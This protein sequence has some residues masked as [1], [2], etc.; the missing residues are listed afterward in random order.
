MNLL[1]KLEENM[2][3][4]GGKWRG[5][6]ENKLFPVKNPANIEEV[7]GSYEVGN[8]QTAR[9]ALEA[10]QAVQKTWQNTPP[11]QRAHYLNRINQLL[12][13][14][15]EQLARILTME[16]GKPIRESIGEVTAAAAHFEWFA[17]EGNRTYGRIIPQTNSAK[18][19]LVM[20]QPIGVSATVS[21][22]NFPLVLFARKVAPALAAGCAVV[23]RPASQTT[24]VAIAAMKLIETAGV[25]QGVLNL[26]TGPACDIVDEFLENPL[27]R[28]VSFTGSTQV[29]R[30]LTEKGASCV[31]HLSLELG[32]NAPAIVFNDAD[33]EVAVKGVLGAKFRNN[34]Q[35]CIAINRIYIHKD[36]IEAFTERF[37]AEVKRL[38]VGN[39]LEPDT[40]LGPMID[41]NSMNKFLR[42]VDDAVSKGGKLVYGGKRL[43]DGKYKKGY[44]ASP[45]VITGA[46]ENMACMCEETF[47]PLAAISAFN[48]MEEVVEK[49][50]ATEH[51][52]AAYI[53]TEST[54][55][56]FLAAEQIEAGTIGINDDVPSTTI[57]PFGGFKQSGLGR[58]CGQEGIEAFMEVKHISIV[59]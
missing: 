36:I 54:K 41:E 5:S 26:V 51:G 52:L 39:G 29:G 40:D 30:A 18:R 46:K 45:A 19:H 44:F 7:V 12:L 24:L 6:P 21:P 1:S 23:A 49:A 10:A 27:C 37:V 25:P 22:W 53:Y 59:L 47:G 13:D 32:G 17:E 11:R 2:M 38:K 31:K 33:L 14:N 55:T 42:Y 48:T 15:K 43:S 50:N 56:A 9:A 8:R 3:F 16:N 34:G 58:E 28:K 35:S 57:A 20:K 4:I